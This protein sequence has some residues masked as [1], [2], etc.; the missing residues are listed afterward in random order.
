MDGSPPFGTPLI[1]QLLLTREIWIIW[2]L[3][4]CYQNE[5]SWDNCISII[6]E[7]LLFSELAWNSHLLVCHFNM[8]SWA[9]VYLSGR[10][11]TLWEDYAN[12]ASAGILVDWGQFLQYFLLSDKNSLCIG[13]FRRSVP[14]ER[15]RSGTS[16]LIRQCEDVQSTFSDA[17]PNVV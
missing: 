9:E 12:Y 15:R 16:F 3:S 8:S 11:D 6:N 1:A 2:S 17:I 7:H 14:S 5:Q 4:K 10:L 13:Y